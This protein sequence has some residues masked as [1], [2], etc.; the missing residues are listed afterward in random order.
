MDSTDGSVDEAR[1]VIDGLGDDAAQVRAAPLGWRD[2]PAD[3]K[4]KLLA[5]VQADLATR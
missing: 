2:A 1:P 3:A 5:A 4:A